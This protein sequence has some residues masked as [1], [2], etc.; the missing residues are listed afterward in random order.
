MSLM[1]KF[2]QTIIVKESIQNIFDEI[3]RNEWTDNKI[4]KSASDIEIVPTF[5]TRRMSVEKYNQQTENLKNLANKIKSNREILEKIG[6]VYYSKEIKTED[7]EK[8]NQF[9]KSI[10]DSYFD[11]RV[12]TK[13]RSMEFLRNCFSKL[14]HLKGEDKN[15]LNQIDISELSN[16]KNSIFLE[17]ISK[18]KIDILLNYDYNK[19]APREKENLLRFLDNEEKKKYGVTDINSFDN[20]RING[21]VDYRENNP[22]NLL[23]DN[24]QDKSP[25]KDES[26]L[27]IKRLLLFNDFRT[28]VKYQGMTDNQIANYFRNTNDIK[29]AVDFYLQDLYG[30]KKLKVIYIFPDGREFSNEFDLIA[31][32][33]ELFAF[34]F[35][36]NPN[37]ST[38]Q[39]IKPDGSAIEINPVT[40]KFIGGLKLPHNVKL[41]VKTY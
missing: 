33:D 17:F 36:V 14:K 27:L 22:Y 8:F 39:L 19:L 30:T 34:V 28:Y 5:E 12:L 40:D 15:L 13:K 16:F 35:N 24:I 9:H 38:P 25:K 32:P 4:Y 10:M 11:D 31:S 26:E 7:T 18:Y 1:V 6:N 37:L 41:I 21:R 23:F 29:Q 20:D 3:K 2:G